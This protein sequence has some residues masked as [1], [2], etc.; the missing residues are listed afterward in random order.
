M[1]TN[2][3]DAL[4]THGGQLTAASF[5]GPHLVPV[6]ELLKHLPLWTVRAIPQRLYVGR[7]SSPYDVDY[8]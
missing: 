2:V 8:I 4:L 5:L 6:V 1:L 3:P 7:L